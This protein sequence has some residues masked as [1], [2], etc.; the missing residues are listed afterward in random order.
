MLIFCLTLVLTLRRQQQQQLR[1]LLMLPLLLP[2]LSTSIRVCLSIC[3]CVRQRRPT[4]SSL[5]DSSALPTGVFL[6]ESHKGQKEFI[7]CLNLFSKTVVQ[8]NRHQ[9]RST[10]RFEVSTQWN[11]ASYSNSNVSDRGYSTC[12]AVGPTVVPNCSGSNSS[13]VNVR[14]ASQSTAAADVHKNGSFRRWFVRT[15][16]VLAWL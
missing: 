15:C 12:K 2:N 13:T 10:T 14:S 6:C 16:V 4:V 3:R 9:R 8:A 7:S 11:C 1:L 5:G